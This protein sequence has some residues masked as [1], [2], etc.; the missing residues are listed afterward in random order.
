M[1]RILLFLCMLIMIGLSCRKSN[2]SPYVPPPA[3]DSLMDWK[4]ISSFTNKHLLDIWFTS[5]QKG[6]L[7]ADHLYQTTDGGNTWTVIPNTSAIKNFFCL[8]FVDAKNGFAYNSSQL[9]TTV[10]GG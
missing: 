10:D 2:Y 7:L 6:F 8:F 1:S 4:V 5:S 3:Q 9:A